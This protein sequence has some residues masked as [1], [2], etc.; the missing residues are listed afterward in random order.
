M[1]TPVNN[2]QTLERPDTAAGA[3]APG[4][5]EL[6]KFLAPRWKLLAGAALGGAVL[7]YGA[8]FL[9][10]PVFTA[11]ASFISPQQQQN[12]AM[13]ALASLGSLGSI[14]GA[15]TGIKSPADQYVALMQS[16][17]ISDRIIKRFGLMEIYDEKFQVDARREL[18]K[19]VRITAGKKDNLI[20]VE[21]DDILPSRAAEMANVY[22]E[23][24]RELSNGLA[25]TEAK[26][27][28]IFFEQQLDSTRTALTKAQVQLQDTGFRAANLR[29]EP[30]AAA[31]TYAR[32]KAELTANEVKL[33]ALRRSR[34]DASPE[35]Q[36]LSAA[37]DGLRR[38]LARIE[39]PGEN[40]PGQDYT[41]AYREYK[42]QESLFEIYAKQYELSRMDEA[43]D[44]T[45]IQVVDA[46]TPPEKKSRPKRLQLA[47]AGFVAGLIAAAVALIV[48]A[49]RRR[50]RA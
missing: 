30:K 33:S 27:R 11:R 48:S 28:R 20:V 10:K 35:V 13:A 21:V 40:A 15:A 3:E 12:S 16:Q 17:T 44:G 49:L 39:A 32:T 29:S 14:A 5:V 26:Q 19:N 50:S 46:A 25:L 41:T 4:L 9:V 7:A 45:F 2:S 8:T 47:I 38:E 6:L 23:E 43:R 37:I 24:L 31:E 34:T 1:A 18:D 42:Y 22:V 36:Q